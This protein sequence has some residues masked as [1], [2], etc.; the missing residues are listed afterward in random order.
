MLEGHFEDST[1]HWAPGGVSHT[2]SS[3]VP[4]GITALQK[5]EE[6]GVPGVCSWLPAGGPTSMVPTPPP[7]LPFSVSCCFRGLESPQTPLDE[8]LRCFP[9]QDLDVVGD[10]MQC[11]PSP[12]LFDPSVTLDPS[13]R[14]MAEAPIDILALEETD[15]GSSSA[16]LIPPAELPAQV[17]P[18][19][20]V[21]HPGM[22]FSQQE[23]PPAPSS[24]REGLLSHPSPAQ[25]LQSL[26]VPMVWMALGVPGWGWQ[27]E[28]GPRG[29]S[30]GGSVP[31]LSWVGMSGT[32]GMSGQGGCLLLEPL[33]PSW[34]FLGE[35]FAR[36][37]VLLS[38]LES[39]FS[40]E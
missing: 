1:S 23:T 17:R 35:L 24:H 6:E 27:P 15:R 10:G 9:C 8:P 4:A 39:Y 19:G 3:S 34:G 2:L 13:L 20:A 26:G 37:G 33:H 36:P 30:V 32:V 14:D 16:P 21:T 11:P 38:S 22:G 29:G 25:Q 18:G 7:P 12:L 40:L 5:E 28:P 31:P